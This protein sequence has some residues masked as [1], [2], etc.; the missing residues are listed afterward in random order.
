MGID[1]IV[2]LC[3]G[4]TLDAS[5]GRGAFPKNKADLVAVNHGQEMFDLAHQALVDMAAHIAS[6]RDAANKPNKFVHGYGVWQHD[7]Q[8]FLNDPNYFLQKRYENI[9]ETLRKALSELHDALKKVG[10]QSKTRLDDME[11]AIVAIAYNTGGYNPSKGLKQG[12]KDDSGRF[13]GEAIFD[14]IRLS[15]TV[16]GNGNPPEIAPPPAGTAI[17]PPPTDISANGRTFVVNTKISPL[18]LRSTPQITDPPGEN[19]IA[20]LPDGQPV[21]AVDGKVT[22]GFRE[23]ETSL[24]GANLHGFAFSKFLVPATANTDIPIVAPEANPPANGIVAVSMPRKDGTITRRVDLADAHSLNEPKQPTRNGTSPTEL[25]D[26]LEAI[27]DW[28]ASDDPD[29]KRYQPRDGLTFCNIYTHDYCML[30]GAYLPRVWW[31]PKAI[32]ALSHGTVVQP[33][34]GDTI[35]EMRANDLFRWLRDF[36]PMFGWRQTGTLTKLQQSAN[37]GGLGIIIARRKEEGRSGH[38]VM[39]IP[40]SDT[41]AASRNAA[42]DVVA[43]LQSQAGAVNFR[44][45]VGRLNWWSDDRFAESA[46]WIHG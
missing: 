8:F 11:K 36:G 45:G 18:R 40:E 13:Y 43:P 33:L 14:F 25:I 9:D 35:D 26:E 5:G 28:L 2:A 38:M 4:D 21:R 10:F 34:I 3:V 37:Q 12:F 17:V 6:Y 20:Q 19:V 44:R 1:Q 16:G 24:S 7:L 22:N 27:I 30:A 32:L 46:F 23:V 39:V 42:G 41:F 29:Y 15:K 31:T